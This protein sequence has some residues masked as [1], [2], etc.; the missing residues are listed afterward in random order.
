M[1]LNSDSNT[2]P[3]AL[4]LCFASLGPSWPGLLKM[5]IAEVQCVDW[6]CC[7]K[8][9]H[10]FSRIICHPIFGCHAGFHDLRVPSASPF[11][12]AVSCWI[13]KSATTVID[14]CLHTEKKQCQI[15]VGCL[16][17]LAAISPDGR[18]VSFAESAYWWAV[19]EGWL[20]LTCWSWTATCVSA[21]FARTCNALV[22]S[23]AIF[24]VWSLYLPPIH[25]HWQIFLVNLWQF[26]TWFLF[27]RQTLLVDR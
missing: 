12:S 22:G 14:V 5:E 10:L 24:C 13:T 7:R 17:H 25:T 1:L 16:V 26:E 20:H 2:S 9:I 27:L 11:K 19:Y 4:T 18:T 21:C 23:K 8:P 15:I 3:V 6:E